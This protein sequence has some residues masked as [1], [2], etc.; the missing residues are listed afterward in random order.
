MVV[1]DGSFS[2][3]F[4]WERVCLSFSLMRVHTAV[5]TAVEFILWQVIKSIATQGARVCRIRLKK[6]SRCCLLSRGGVEN[7]KG[8]GWCSGWWSRSR[9]RAG[10]QPLCGGP[11]PGK[12][13][14]HPCTMASSRGKDSQMPFSLHCSIPL[15]S[16]WSASELRGGGFFF[17]ADPKPQFRL[18]VRAKDAQPLGCPW[19]YFCLPFFFSFKRGSQNIQTALSNVV[20]V[21]L[22]RWQSTFAW[23]FQYYKY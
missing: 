13:N 2:F 23:S 12:S 14:C 3:G 17:P 20:W 18:W 21:S 9:S 22:F 6:S 15:A 8:G 7:S 5:H 19:R 4:C 16:R 11:L 1:Q 10:A